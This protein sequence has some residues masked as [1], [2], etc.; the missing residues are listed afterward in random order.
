MLSI[1]LLF[2][3]T[4]IIFG[5]NSSSL[6]S[7]NVVN[8]SAVVHQIVTSSTILP[9]ITS[10]SNMSS[11]SSAPSTTQSLHLTS[12]GKT[13]FPTFSSKSTASSRQQSTLKKSISSKPISFR[14]VSTVQESFSPTHISF[15][16]S[17][18][19]GKSTSPTTTASVCKNSTNKVDV[20]GLDVKTE[21]LRNL[22]YAASVLAVVCLIAL[23]VV[24]CLWRRQTR[25]ITK[26]ER[27]DTALS[28]PYVN[29]RVEGFP[30]PL[31]LNSFVVKPESPYDTPEA[32]EAIPQDAEVSYVSVIDGKTNGNESESDYAAVK[33]NGTVNSV[34]DGESRDNDPLPSPDYTNASVFEM[35]PYQE[36][37]PT[38]RSNED[39]YTSLIN[40]DETKQNED[41]ATM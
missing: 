18:F 13:I 37:M 7:S 9:T 25:T 38:N 14:A 20:F 11:R 2:G 12:P 40:I 19:P 15:S 34:D 23:I 27:Q 33:E 41:E 35:D 3:L 28:N 36:L 24:C 29:T 26:L 22:F 4:G 6:Q 8:T 39:H 16:S 5:F 1:V 17:T 21:T 30:S 32:V 10:S 31:Q